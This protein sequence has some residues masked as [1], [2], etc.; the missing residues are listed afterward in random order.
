MSQEKD[1]VRSNTVDFFKGLIK[2]TGTYYLSD[3]VENY[4]EFDQ[5]VISESDHAKIV[6]NRDLLRGQ[7]NEVGLDIHIIS[8]EVAND[9]LDG[10]YSKAEECEVT[11]MG[12]YVNSNEENNILIAEFM[13]W[14]QGKEDDHRWSK[15]WFNTHKERVTDGLNI[16]LSFHT[17][18]DWLMPVI[19]KCYS[20]ISPMLDGIN[21]EVEDSLI[22]DITM[23]LTD[24]R[25]QETFEAVSVAIDWYNKNKQLC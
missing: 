6:A 5:D 23:E 18:W 11:P 25:L 13:G 12:E 10:A 24:G 17:S 22:G 15:D 8:L 9:L 19:Q 1:T 3:Y 21:G 16:I 4:S 14:K 7:C 20:E 2:R